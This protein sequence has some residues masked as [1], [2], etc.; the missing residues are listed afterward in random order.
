MSGHES[1]VVRHFTLHWVKLS[2][3]D[4]AAPWSTYEWSDYAASSIEIWID[5]YRDPTNGNEHQLSGILRENSTLDVVDVGRRGDQWKW[6]R[7]AD[8]GYRG[9]SCL[10][11]G[12]RNTAS[13]RY[14]SEASVRVSG[15]YYGRAVRLE[16]GAD[17]FCGREGAT[18]D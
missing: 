8:C 3:L 5:Q 16:C 13:G 1:P 14:E 11:V 2:S 4:S 12:P 7:F 18:R 15:W 9:I 10:G 6:A 17:A